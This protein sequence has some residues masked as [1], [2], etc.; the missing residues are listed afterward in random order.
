MALQHGWTALVQFILQRG[1]D[2]GMIVAGVVDTV[3]GEKVEDPAAIL[4][5]KF[6]PGT[7]SIRNV[8]LQEV[9][10]RH[11]LRINEVFI[12]IA[13]YFFFG[14]RLNWGGHGIMDA[15]D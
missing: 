4:G 5:E 2:M 13:G 8:H 7:G 10:Q 12:K 9:E 14:N 6:R 1:D 3:A 11:P 15:P